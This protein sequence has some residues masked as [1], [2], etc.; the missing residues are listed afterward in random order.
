MGGMRWAERYMDVKTRVEALSGAGGR[1]ITELGELL[2]R[3]GVVGMC[4]LAQFR[5]GELRRYGW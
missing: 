3:V 2:V 5:S 4:C 1:L